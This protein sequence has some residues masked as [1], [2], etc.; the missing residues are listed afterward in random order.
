VEPALRFALPARIA[1]QFDF[2][3]VRRNGPA[4]LSAGRRGGDCESPDLLATIHQSGTRCTLGFGLV[5]S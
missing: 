5:L 2:S 1:S 3:L 4:G